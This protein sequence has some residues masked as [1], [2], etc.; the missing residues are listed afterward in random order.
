VQMFGNTP[1]AYSVMNCTLNILHKIDN[2]ATQ[3]GL[4]LNQQ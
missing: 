1:N 3:T 2:V 4:P